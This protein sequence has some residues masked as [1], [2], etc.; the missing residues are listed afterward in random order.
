MCRALHYVGSTLVLL[1]IALAISLG[2]VW[3][4]LLLPI[5]GYGPAWLGHY[6]FEHNRPATFTHPIYSFLADWLMF[7]QWVKSLYKIKP[8]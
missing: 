4:L 1:L 7:T 5:V 6:A 8:K 3:V 2:N